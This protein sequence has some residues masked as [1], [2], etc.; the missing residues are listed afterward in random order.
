MTFN[1]EN[2]IKKQKDW[3]DR[4]FPDVTQEAIIKHIKKELSEI[5]ED[6]NDVEE[7]V[8]VIILAIHGALKI[9]GV[10][11]EVLALE[12]ISKQRKNFQ[13]K[14]PEKYDINEPVE[15]VKG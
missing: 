15:H 3:I 2:Y 9:E 11:P 12:L 4:Q 8:D 1:I 6:L 7:W 14:W 13:R 10:T 5:E